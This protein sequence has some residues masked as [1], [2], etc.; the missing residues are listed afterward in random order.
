MQKSENDPHCSLFRMCKIRVNFSFLPNYNTKKKRYRFTAL[1]RIG[2]THVFL[3]IRDIIPG[4]EG[5]IGFWKKPISMLG[6]PNISLLTLSVISSN[7]I[8]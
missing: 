6:P 1:H 2:Y 5:F 3:N 8:L 4:F 7:I